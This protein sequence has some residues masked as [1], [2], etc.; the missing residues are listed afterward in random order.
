[1][2]Y[3]TPLLLVFVAGSLFVA[4]YQPKFS[5]PGYYCDPDKN[6]PACPEGQSCVNGRCV[7]KGRGNNVDDDVDMKVSS[8]PTDLKGA[9]LKKTTD[10][11]K[12][13]STDGNTCGGYVACVNACTTDTCVSNCQAA[14]DLEGQDLIQTAVDCIYTYCEFTAGDCEYDPFSGGYIDAIGADF[15]ACDACTGNAAADLTM[16]P[17]QP[18][19]DPDCKPAVCKSDIQACF[20]DT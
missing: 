7:T 1:M 6:D 19:N 18:T 17:C 10:L 20:N 15:G 16:Q 4:C 2:R 13:G 9:D 8:G 12:P 11:S 14:L 3:L 5:S